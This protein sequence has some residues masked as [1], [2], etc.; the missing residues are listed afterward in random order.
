MELQAATNAPTFVPNQTDTFF[1]R[2][3]HSVLDIGKQ[4]PKQC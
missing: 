3:I 4:I 2:S 1:D